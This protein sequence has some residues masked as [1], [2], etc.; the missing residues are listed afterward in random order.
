MITLALTNESIDCP[1]TEEDLARARQCLD[2]R[3]GDSANA[4]GTL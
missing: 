2:G 4:L 1:E 3:R